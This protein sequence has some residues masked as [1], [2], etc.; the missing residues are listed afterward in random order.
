VDVVVVAK[1]QKLSASK[2]GAIVS[3]DGVWH[4]KPV[5]DVSEK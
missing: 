3:D 4:S 1:L 5:D 2:L